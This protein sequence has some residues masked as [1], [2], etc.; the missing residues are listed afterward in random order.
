MYYMIDN[1]DSFVFNLYAYMK[2][3]GQDVVVRRADAVS[4]EELEA[5]KPEGIIISPGPKRPQDADVSRKILELYQGAVP[6]LGVCLGHQLIGY[7]YGAQVCHG[8]R[9][10]HGKIS[11]INHSGQEIFQDLPQQYKVTRYHSLVVSEENLPQELQVTA[12]TEDGVIMGLK[13]TQYPVYGIQF[14]PEAVLTEYGHEL[15]QNF[16]RICQ[17]WKNTER[18]VSA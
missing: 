1:Y 18:R 3:N 7:H 17:D 8:K 2:E 5:L 16:H 12:R 14:H 11:K 10:E 9:P 15:L 6:I 13:H 4:F